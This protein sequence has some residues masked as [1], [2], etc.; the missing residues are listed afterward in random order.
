MLS[1]NYG[2]SP[3]LE[4]TGRVGLIYFLVDSDLDP[5]GELTFYDIPFW[6]GARYSIDPSGQGFYLHGE[7]AINSYHSKFGD[8]SDS[9]TETGANLL[10]GAKMGNL[11]LEGGLYIGSF[12]ESESKMLGATV[13]TTF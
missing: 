6:F 8:Q 12:D 2:A 7:L 3:Q 10:A 1:V 4:L 9:E 5:N 11:M 13:G